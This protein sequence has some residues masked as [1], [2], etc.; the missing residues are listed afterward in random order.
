MTVVFR[1]DAM[2]TNT[3]FYAL[4][5]AIQQDERENGASLRL[6]NG[7]HRCEGRVEVFYNGTWGT[8]CDDSWDLTDVRVVCQQLG[9][10]EALSAPAQSY[11][12]GG[13]GHIMLD[14]IQC[15]GNEAKVWQCTH[16]GW[17]SHNCG[18][19]ED[20]SAICS[21]VDGNPKV[22]PKD[23]TGDGPAADENFHCGGLLT[24]NSGSFSSPWYPKKYPINVVCAWDIHVD[25]R[26]HVKLTFEVVKLENFYGCPYD[27]IEVFDGPQSES[28]SLGRF[29]SGTTPTFT[30]SSNRLTVVF[31]SDAIVTNMGFYASYES[32]VQDE[33]NTA[34]GAGQGSHLTLPWSLFH[35]THMCRLY[36]CFRCCPPRVA[37]TRI[38]PSG[39]PA[40]ATSAR[41]A[42]SC[43]TMALGG[44]CVMTAGTCVM[45]RWCVGSCPVAGRCWPPAG[46]ISA[47]AWAPL[48]WM[49]WSVWGQKPGCGS[50]CTVAGSPT[51]VATTKMPASSVQPLCLTQ[52]HQLLQVTQFQHLSR[53]R[54]KF[55][56]Q[57]VLQLLGVQGSLLQLLGNSRVSSIQQFQH[58]PQK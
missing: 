37:T 22:G 48:P 40:A 39:W 34:Q 6:V 36:T 30:S 31:H 27:F 54:Q 49:T 29:C 35:S 4:Y 10:G 32:I 33:I 25:A 23:S 51:T 55:P 11:F 20:A 12:D 18:H 38:W 8:L 3:G 46:H 16:N 1:S 19:H 9:C 44:Q 41:A 42:W 47:K 24:N 45:P 26:A 15:T 5:N 53:S 28:F 56:H 7:S 50:A 2:I 43:T 58:Q 17:F 13:T 52:H 14:D 21:G 57:R